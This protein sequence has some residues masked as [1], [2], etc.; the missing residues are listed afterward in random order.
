LSAA[1]KLGVSRSHC[2]KYEGDTGKGRW[3]G[4]RNPTLPHKKFTPTPTTHTLVHEDALY[5]A[6]GGT[7]PL[8]STARKKKRFRAL[9]KRTQGTLPEKEG[10]VRR[11]EGGTNSSLTVTEGLSTTARGE[12][13]FQLRI[14]IKNAE[15]RHRKIAALSTTWV[16]GREPSNWGQKPGSGSQVRTKKPIQLSNDFLA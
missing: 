14:W 7:P 3:G 13:V 4:E 15:V 1:E 16:E 11:T 5:Q 6:S 12:H 9:P 2:S 8:R 10:G